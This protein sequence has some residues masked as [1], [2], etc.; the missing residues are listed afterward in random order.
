MGCSYDHIAVDWLPSACI[1]DELTQ[2]FDTSGPRSGGSWPYYES[3]TATLSNSSKAESIIT[4]KQIDEFAKHGK[5]YFATRQE[6]GI[7]STAC[8]FGRNNFGPGLIPDILSRAITKKSIFST[9]ATT[10][11]RQ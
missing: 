9:T 5:G 2:K 1:D 11:C 10:S 3:V 7:S 8:L 4:N 6:S